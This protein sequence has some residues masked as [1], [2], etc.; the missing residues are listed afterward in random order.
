MAN[1]DN[2]EE[3][4][5]EFLL[6]LLR[7]PGVCTKPDTLEE[8]RPDLNQF[9]IEEYKGLLELDK[10]RNERFDRLVTLF[11]SLAG[12]PWALY[13]LV[14]KDGKGT[15]ALAEMPQLI[16][17]VFLLVGLLGFLVV[18]MCIQTKFLITLYMRAVNAIRG[19]FDA[20]QNS[21][22]LRLPT[23][24]DSPPYFEKG[25]YNFYAALGMALVN[26]SYVSL[27][28]YRLSIQ[29]QGWKWLGPVLGI[30]WVTIHF[31]YYVKQ[32]SRREKGDSGDE[33]GFRGSSAVLRLW[34]FLRSFSP[35]SKPSAPK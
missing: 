24:H 10:A 6:F 14:I 12:A 30:V 23:K 35:A 32:A 9:L 18:I 5:P 7:N 21:A 16:A 11:L 28:C 8:E 3:E 4:R 13:V 27:A 33:L 34:Q 31:L 2:L 22:A 17:W 26:A 20:G 29:W 15:F 19:H 25:S 1:H